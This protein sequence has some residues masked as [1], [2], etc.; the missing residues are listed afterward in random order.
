MHRFVLV[1]VLACTV[2]VSGQSNLAEQYLFSAANAE[3]AAA[4][5]APLR[6]SATLALAASRHAR[7]MAG[8][9]DISHR[10]ANEAELADRGAAAGA[11]FTLIA[12]NVAEAPSATVLHSAWMQS[13]GHRANLLD[14]KVDAVGIAVVMRD[15]QLYAVEDFARV[16]EPLSP[17]AQEAIVAGALEAA[18]LNLL[19]ASTGARATCAQASGYTGTAPPA[20]ILRYTTADLR[21]LPAQLHQR[22]AGRLYTSAAVGACLS[23][24]T[25]PFTSYHIAV[26][27]YR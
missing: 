15:R 5:V 16:T 12:E 22:I 10:F 23:T 26:L 18:G 8:H 21:E 20:F 4:G 11:R 2:S 1:A 25:T 13:V 9:R 7:E 24:T 3:R 14:A 17:A 19:P 27:L 6:W